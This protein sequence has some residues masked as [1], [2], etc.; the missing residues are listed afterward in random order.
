VATALCH[1]GV[2][3]PDL[4]RQAAS[5]VDRILRGINSARER[6]KLGKTTEPRTLKLQGSF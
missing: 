3:V 6:P 4:Y 1:S 5:Y 2:D